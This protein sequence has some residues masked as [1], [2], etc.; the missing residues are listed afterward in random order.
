MY[1]IMKVEENS[2]LYIKNQQCSQGAVFTHT[3]WMPCS[4]TVVAVC[5]HIPT[6][7]WIL[8]CSIDNK[9]L[10]QCGSMRCVYTMPKYHNIPCRKMTSCKGIQYHPISKSRKQSCEAQVP[11]IKTPIPSAWETRRKG[12][13]HGECSKSADQVAYNCPHHGAQG[14]QNTQVSYQNVIERNCMMWHC[15]MISSPLRL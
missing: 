1:N 3:I 8:A 14:L 12:A 15:G 5:V 10:F 2:L 7:H 9:R 11:L 13:V 6:V 4:K